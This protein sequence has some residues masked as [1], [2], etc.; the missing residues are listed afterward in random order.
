MAG[1]GPRAL[2]ASPPE[3]ALNLTVLARATTRH[4]AH[5]LFFTKIPHFHLSKAT[6]AMREGLA[7]NNLTHLYKHEPTPR[8]ALDIHTFLHQH[9]FW[10]QDNKVVDKCL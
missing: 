3:P 8:F 4:V 10:V 6:K 1:W 5:H 2:P 7:K 9:Y